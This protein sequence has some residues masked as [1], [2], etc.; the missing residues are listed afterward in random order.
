MVDSGSTLGIGGVMQQMVPV[1]FLLEVI[2]RGTSDLHCVGVAAGLSMDLMLAAGAAGRISCAIVSFE[3]FGPAHAM[4]RK[5]EAGEAR[6]DEYTELTMISRLEAAGRGLPYLPTLAALGTDVAAN[7]SDDAVR[8]VECPFTGRPLLACR[9]LAPDVAVIHAE[10]AD[11]L[12]NVQLDGKHVWHDVVLA[13]AAKKVIVTV[14][15]TVG[16]DAVRADPEATIL[17]GFVVDAVVEAPGGT[18]PSQF[19]GRFEV[20]A[21]AFG[22]WQAAAPDE[23]SALALIDRWAADHPAPATGTGS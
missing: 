20:D 15:R 1:A 8:Q 5:V 19:P 2:R 6:Y 16:S 10:R 22:D 18:W 3:E 9:A 13:R 14:E 17:P 21:E 12:G 11:P 4:R 23:A 7:L